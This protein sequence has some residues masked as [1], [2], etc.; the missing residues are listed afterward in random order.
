MASWPRGIGAI[1]LFVEELDAAKEFY[2]EVF[3]LPV[4]FEDDN[5]AVFNFGNTI[6]NL[7]KTTAA[8][9]LIDPA[10]VASRETGA[11][12]QFTIRVDD[13]DAMCAE[14]AS[15]GVTLLT[16]PLELGGTWGGSAPGDAAAVIERMRTACLAGVTLVSDHQPE[17]LRV[18]DHA[19]P[20]TE[21]NRLYIKSLERFQPFVACLPSRDRPAGITDRATIE[22]EIQRFQA[23]RARHER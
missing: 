19:D 20:L 15:R 16:A 7:L 2:R 5:S 14:L 18:D 13:V 10:T 23:E 17:K 9:G 6:I 22:A 12:L 1:T 3:G 11:R 4:A 8:Q 21:L